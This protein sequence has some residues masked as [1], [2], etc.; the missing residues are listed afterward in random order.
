[1]IKNLPRT[2]ILSQFY[3]KCHHLDGI[4]ENYSKRLS[5]TLTNLTQ[6]TYREQELGTNSSVHFTHKFCDTAK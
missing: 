6:E 3:N 5:K 4:M 1:M 2:N